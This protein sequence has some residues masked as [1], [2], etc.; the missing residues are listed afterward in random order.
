MLVHDE[1]GV[2][3]GGSRIGDRAPVARAGRAC[4][5][6]DL[7]ATVR[8]L[9]RQSARVCEP[10]LEQPRRSAAIDDHNGLSESDLTMYEIKDGAWVQAQ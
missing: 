9:E 8:H 4:I 5:D 6:D 2:A 1:R 3:G 10:G 7:C